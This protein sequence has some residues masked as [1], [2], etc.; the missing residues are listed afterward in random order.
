VSG[1]KRTPIHRRALGPHVTPDVVALFAE[2][3]QT[4]AR[5]R[6]GDQFKA[7]EHELARKLNLVSEWWTCN[8]VLDTSRSPCHPS[9]YIAN[10]HWHRVR[11][12]REALLA[13]AGL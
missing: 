2:L 7:V 12:V 5:K 10:A 11:R 8:S 3:E 13:A 1:T 4:P 9:G 6:R